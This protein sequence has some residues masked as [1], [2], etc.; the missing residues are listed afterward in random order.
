HPIYRDRVWRNATTLFGL[1]RSFAGLARLFAR[2]RPQ[3][4]V[5]TGGY[6][7]APTGMMAV[8]TRVPLAVQ[9]QNSFPGVTVRALARY[10]AQVHLGFPEA[11]HELRR[12]RATEVFALGNP[13]RP[14]A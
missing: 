8:A 7:S 11:T 3:L 10:A 14:P 5:A 9:E 12:G 13:I 6:A 1:A 4:V 2:L